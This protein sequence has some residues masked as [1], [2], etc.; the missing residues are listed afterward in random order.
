MVPASRT[1]P[2]LSSRRFALSAGE[3]ATTSLA[4]VVST[5]AY[6]NLG[7]PYLARGVV[8]DLLGFGLLAAVGL[9]LRARVT[10]E[11][12][13]CLGLIGLVVVASPSWPLAVAE[14]IWWGLFTLGL[15]LYVGVRRRLCD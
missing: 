12:A 13:W 3:W 14:P 1:R 7:L 9:L 11:A 6:L 15:V 10:H 8:G 5:V 4:A 2:G